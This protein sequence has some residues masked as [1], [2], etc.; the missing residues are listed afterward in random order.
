M[1]NPQTVQYD[2]RYGRRRIL[3]TEGSS[4]RKERP[5]RRRNGLLPPRSAKEPDKRNTD[6]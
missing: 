4:V 1:A 2:Q 3:V 5:D 6:L